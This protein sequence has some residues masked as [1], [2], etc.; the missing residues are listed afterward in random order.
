MAVHLVVS[1]GVK[2]VASLSGKW[3]KL[4]AILIMENLHKNL[5]Q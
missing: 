3:V 5:G 2:Q 1:N 4:P